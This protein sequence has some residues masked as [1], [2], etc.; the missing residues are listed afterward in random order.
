MP[1]NP[2]G[3]QIRVSRP[4]T[5]ISV[6]W[7]QTQPFVADQ[8]FPPV[9]VRRQGDLYWKYDRGD[10]FQA[11]AEKR[12]P[13]TESAGGGWNVTTDSYFAHVYAVHQDLDDQTM[14]NAD[15]QFNLESD[16]ALW[17]TQQLGMK[18]EQL[19]VSTYMQAN[20]WG[21][22][23]G[24]GDEDVAGAWATISSDIIGAIRE[25]R[26]QIKRTTGFTP[27]TLVVDDP[28]IE[29]MMENTAILDRIKYTQRGYVTLELIA[30][31]LDLERIV[32]INAVQQSTPGS[33]T[34]EYMTGSKGKALLCYANPRPGLRQPSAGY[35]FAWTG[36]LG[37]GATG[38]R[39]KRFRMEALESTRI[40]G[41]MAFV[42]KVVA[43][44]LGYLF[45][46]TVLT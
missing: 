45:E 26:M 38:I 39:Q 6:A 7:Q 36:L 29:A 16:A 9:P 1:Q 15:E 34:L 22:G 33:D 37:S 30:S 40:E 21:D 10:W 17:T 43:P 25:K 41:E 20:V 13:G 18:K 4:L 42:Q 14:A 46:D 35:T 19:F 3:T 8:V 2:D 11:L 28:T 5:N 23:S 31:L 27:N 32:S 12:A 24:S 44:E